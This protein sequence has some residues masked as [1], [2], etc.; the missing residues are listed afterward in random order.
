MVYRLSK[1][2]IKTKILFFCVIWIFSAILAVLGA[3]FITTAAILPST[4]YNIQEN[5]LIR[6]IRQDM[7][8]WHGWNYY[9]EETG[10]W[11]PNVTIQEQEGK[12]LVYTLGGVRI[13]D[14]RPYRLEEVRANGWVVFFPEVEILNFFYNDPDTNNFTQYAVHIGFR[15]AIWVDINSHELV[16]HYQPQKSFPIF[17]LSD[18]AAS[19][20]SDRGDEFVGNYYTVRN[21]PILDWLRQI[22]IAVGEN[23]V[24]EFL[25]VGNILLITVAV[26]GG[27]SIFTAFFL[28][29]FRFVRLIGG[30]FWTYMVLKMLNGK[31][32]K[33]LGYI[34]V[35][36]FNGETYVEQ[37]FVNTINLSGLRSTLGELYRQRAYDILFFPTALAA[38]LTILFVQNSPVENKVTALV[39][40]PILSPL[41]LLILLFYFP[42]IWS[43]NEGGFKRIQSSPQ[44][45]IVAVKPLGKILRDGLGI[46][47]GFS[48]IISLGALS[49]QV[50]ESFAGQATS[51]EGIQVAGFSLDLF[52]IALLILWTIGLFLILLASV[53]VGAS[54]IAVTYLQSA[55]LSTIKELRSRSEKDQVISNF[56]SLSTQFKPKGIETIYSTDDE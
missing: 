16:P 34:P 30:R 11:F 14:F 55:H 43:F 25:L 48:G 37:S 51:S 40:S 44:G 49:V 10:D 35:F 7:G 42:V 28:I 38:I 52:G 27:A 18:E 19:T 39:W 12:L 20:G 23:F 2:R 9:N 54:L 22:I 32:G 3:M 15:E 45:D 53:I 13:P 1:M 50:T 33:V 24:T 36:D 26:G 17:L 5:Q 29:I 8:G 46:I 47:I 56:G 41:V 31:T 21:R 4:P 6:D